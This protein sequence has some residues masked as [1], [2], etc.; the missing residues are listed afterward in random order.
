MVLA[1]IFHFSNVPPQP[2]HAMPA[3][4]PSIAYEAI[5]QMRQQ[6]HKYITKPR[7]Y[8]LHYPPK[9]GNKNTNH[10]VL[11]VIKLLFKKQSRNNISSLCLLIKRFHFSTKRFLVA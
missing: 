8:K 11:Y 4:I 9:I 5:Y 6:F 7:N 3:L 10:K 1:N 2:K